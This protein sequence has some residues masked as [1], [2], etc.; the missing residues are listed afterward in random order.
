MFLSGLVFL[1]P[2]FWAQPSNAH[3]SLHLLKKPHAIFLKQ[4]M[5]VSLIMALF[6]L[7]ENVKSSNNKGLTVLH[8]SQLA[9]AYY[10]KQLQAFSVSVHIQPNYLG[11]WI[12][13]L[14]PN[15]LVLPSDQNWGSH[16]WK[17][18]CYVHFNL[19]SHIQMK[20]KIWFEIFWNSRDSR[21]ESSL[22]HFTLMWQG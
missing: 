20:E 6:N 7:A 11:M 19:L 13:M 16:L 4:Q 21:T 17:T 9:H 12:W 10:R 8:A 5:E 1:V 3:R 15:A 22:A 14:S 18:M 2:L